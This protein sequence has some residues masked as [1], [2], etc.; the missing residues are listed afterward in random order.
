LLSQHRGPYRLSCP[1]PYNPVELRTAVG[2]KK[3][4][5]IKPRIR[6]P[7][8]GSA[9]VANFMGTEERRKAPWVG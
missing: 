2:L 6:P 3:A 1:H 5:C 7:P 4:I 9:R 8:F